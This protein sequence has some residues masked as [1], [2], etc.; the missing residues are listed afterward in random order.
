[1]NEVVYADSAALVLIHI[2]RTYAA[3]G[4]TDILASAECLGETVELDMPRHNDVS[5]GVY[6]EV[7]GGYA[8]CLE[9]V[10]LAYEVLG[11]ENYTCADKAEGVLVENTRGNEVE[12]VY[13]TVINY[14]MTSVVTAL[15]AYN[16]IGAGGDDVDYLTL[17]FVSPLCTNNNISR[18]C[19]SSFHNDYSVHKHNYN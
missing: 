12:L 9:A 8:S 16:N 2:C 15:R 1:M 14:G 4:S 11:V 5:A 19:D 7:S 13:L 3:L 17:S 18:H 6:L 10:E